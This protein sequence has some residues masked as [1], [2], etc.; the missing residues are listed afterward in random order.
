MKQPLRLSQKWADK[1]ADE[2]ETGM[3]YQVVT[4]ALK[5]GRQ[6]KRVAIIQSTLVGV[7][8]GMDHIP[9]TEDEIADIIVT[10][11]KWDFQTGREIGELPHP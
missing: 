1:L 7:I 11:D 10:H 5:D 4:V 2:G 3:G 8:F 6:V 9:F